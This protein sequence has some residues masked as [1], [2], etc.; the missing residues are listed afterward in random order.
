MQKLAICVVLCLHVWSA[1]CILDPLEE[2]HNSSGLRKIMAGIND[3]AANVGKIGMKL[4]NSSRD[5]GVVK[6]KEVHVQQVWEVTTWSSVDDHERKDHGATGSP[7]SSKVEEHET[8]YHGKPKP[9]DTLAEHET[10][11]HRSDD[12]HHT[13]NMREHEAKYHNNKREPC[14]DINQ[15]EVKHHGR[16]SDIEEHVRNYHAQRGSFNSPIADHESHFHGVYANNSL[17]LEEHLARFH[18]NERYSPEEDDK[19][20][21]K[22]HEELLHGEPR[23]PYKR[24]AKYVNKNANWIFWGSAALL[25]LALL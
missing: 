20:R 19:E 24:M 7:R 15:H 22:H 5:S 9:S 21:M 18:R 23:C 1:H 4:F 10:Q 13:H 14:A 25:T 12:A 11:Y 6:V 2:F 17:T 8:K 3:L 16:S